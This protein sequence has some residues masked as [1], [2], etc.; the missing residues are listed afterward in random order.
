MRRLIDTGVLLRLF[1]RSDANHV[2]IR[3]A[4]RRLRAVG[5][6]L[7][8]T[9]QNIAEFWSVS[10]RPQ[11][12]R[13]GYGQTPEESNRRVDFIE[14]WGEV[15]PEAPDAYIEWRRLLV[16]HAVRGVSVHDCRI[17]A[18]MRSSG[19]RSIVTLNGKDFA[20]YEGIEAMAPEDLL[21]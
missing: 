19:I 13:G 2:A 15:L 21:R 12:A 8:T 7:V 4:L 18:L 9:Q 6:T 20:R 16:K 1:D 17:A 5:D 3:D 11:S 10:T 14:N